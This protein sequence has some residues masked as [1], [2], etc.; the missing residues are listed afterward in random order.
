MPVAVTVVKMIGRG[1]VKVHR[2]L[3]QTQTEDARIE[4]D[5]RL[6]IPCDCR[7][8]MNARNFVL[9]T[10]LTLRHNSYASAPKKPAYQ[11][12]SLPQMADN[13]AALGSVQQRHK[14][15]EGEER[16]GEPHKQH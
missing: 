1:V 16:T 10:H 9:H 15:K 6:R 5:V 11:P 3:D 12:E 14:R 8:M 7:H 4:I 2:Q 13:P